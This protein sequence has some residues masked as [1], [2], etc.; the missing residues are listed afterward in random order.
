VILR[1]LLRYTQRLRLY[2]ERNILAGRAAH[3]DDVGWQAEE[4]RKHPTDRTNGGS[5]LALNSFQ[6]VRAVAKAVELDAQSLR[7]G[8]VQVTHRRGV[9]RLKPLSRLQRSAATASE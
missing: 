8:Q 1:L 5:A 6:N 9:G 3:P 2:R 7:E 4:D